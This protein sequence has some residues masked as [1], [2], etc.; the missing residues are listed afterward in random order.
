MEFL[1]PYINMWTNYATFSGRTRRRD[2]WMAYLVNI[3]ISFILGILASIA[4]FFNI[5][6][7]LYGLAIIV[8]SLALCWRRLHDIGKSGGWYF[9]ALV[10]A[11]GWI[12][13]LVFLCQ[14]SQPGANA[15]GPNP[16]GM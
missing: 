11:V 2:F 7:G 6:I 1:Q 14:D 13:L 15:Y 5:L 9:I 12:I 8:P 3:I 16:K 10:P 4:S